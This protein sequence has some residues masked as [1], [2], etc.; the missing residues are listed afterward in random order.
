MFFIVGYKR[1]VS[2]CIRKILRVKQGQYRAG[3]SREECCCRRK[4]SQLIV[5][6]SMHTPL[7]QFEKALNVETFVVPPA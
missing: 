7:C 4:M 6:L 5:I 1:C 3:R 2:D